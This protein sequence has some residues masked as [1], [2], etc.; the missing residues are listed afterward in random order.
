WITQQPAWQQ[1]LT[2]KKLSASRNLII[3]EYPSFKWQNTAIDGYGGELKLVN[4]GCWGVCIGSETLNA[5]A[6][7]FNVIDVRRPSL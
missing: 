2:R 5:A 4:K 3:D 1:R 7:T 6:A